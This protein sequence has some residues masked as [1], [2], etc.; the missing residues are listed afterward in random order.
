LK[1]NLTEDMIADVLTKPFAKD[2]HQTLTKAINLKAFD[3][4]QSESVGDRT[5]DYS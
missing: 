4:S 1:C 3:Y 2:M 5:L